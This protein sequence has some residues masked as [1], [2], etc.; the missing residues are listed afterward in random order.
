MNENLNNSAPQNAS[1]EHENTPKNNKRLRL[2]S[3]LFM[4]ALIAVTLYVIFRDTSL[5]EFWTAVQSS[6]PLWLLAAL[7]AALLASLMFGVALHLALRVLYGRRIPFLRNLGFGFIGQYYTAITPAGVAGQPMQLYYMIAY[8]VEVSFASLSLLLVNAS[9]QL[10]VLLIPTV[11][12]PFRSGLILNNLGAFLW[13]F[14]L[15]SLINIG[16]ILF[17]LFAMFSKNFAG[18][19]VHKAIALLTKLRIVKHPERIEKRVNDQIMLYQKGA[20]VFR[21]HKWLLA[22]ELFTYMLLLGSQFVIP[23]FVYRAFHLTAFGMIDFIALQSVLYLAVCFLPIPGSAGASESGFVQI[24]RVLFQSALIVPAMLLS[25]VASFYFIL[26][27]SGAVS[28]A[29]QLVLSARQKKK[30]LEQTPTAE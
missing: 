3:T 16:L 2:I 5:G 26:I 4:L 13:L 30:R 7:G 17:L 29:M 12:F 22:A 19:I 23:Y 18:K 21:A 1:P 14:I 6:D 15:G 27:L 20:E 24:F 8:G 28:L 10:V 9:H 25:R 11:L